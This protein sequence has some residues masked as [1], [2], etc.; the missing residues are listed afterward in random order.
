MRDELRN[1]LKDQSLNDVSPASFA[2]VGGVVFPDQ[3]AAFS[4]ADFGTIVEA[5]RH[6]HLPT[7]GSAIARSAKTSSVNSNGD[8]LTVSGNQVAVVQAIQITTTGG[9][10]SIV[11]LNLNGVLVS[12][13]T[14]DPAA[15]Q[16]VVLPY[17]LVVD[18]NSPLS[19]AES[20]ADITL[21]CTYYMISQ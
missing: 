6:V 5:F 13:P 18:V 4:L 20:S 10:P 2:Q 16:P 14:A 19:V 17:P 11:A 12:N 21:V 7:Y 15:T 3:G 8:L 1:L 9:D